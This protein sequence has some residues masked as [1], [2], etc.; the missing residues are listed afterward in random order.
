[1]TCILF[2]PEKKKSLQSKQNHEPANL[3]FDP[4]HEQCCQCWPY[5]PNPI[6]LHKFQTASGIACGISCGLDIWDVWA[7]CDAE[8]GALSL[9]RT[10]FNTVAHSPVHQISISRM[11]IANIGIIFCGNTL[12]TTT[13]VI[14]A[15]CEQIT[16]IIMPITGRARCFCTNHSVVAIVL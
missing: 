15:R 12:A 7:Y 9:N 8:A 13:Y 2:K 16:K 10:F 1:M 14:E 5:R 4:D 11:A 3:S 6:V